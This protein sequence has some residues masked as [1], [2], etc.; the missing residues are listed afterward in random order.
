MCT[1][2]LFGSNPYCRQTYLLK[3]CSSLFH[4]PLRTTSKITKAEWDCLTAFGVMDYCF[5]K[6]RAPLNNFLPL[7]VQF[8]TL[9]WFIPRSSWHLHHQHL[10]FH[11][12]LFPICPSVCLS[13][14]PATMNL[15]A[16]ALQLQANIKKAV[17]WQHMGP[18][19]AMHVDV[20]ENAN[21]PM[22]TYVFVVMH[23]LCEHLYVCRGMS[24]SPWA[25]M[26][27]NHELTI[28]ALGHKNDKFE[29]CACCSHWR[30]FK[31]K[32][33]HPEKK[34]KGAKLQLN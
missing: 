18:Y 30:L 17:W 20:M 29:I 32:W 22:C 23:I 4:F 26:Y 21:W 14:L 33:F 28:R 3:A 9:N 10:S 6:S 13:I 24:L 2:T 15:L 27:V 25:V 19:G 1:H 8:A 34:L 11:L 7:W 12:S 5:W 16:P 31:L